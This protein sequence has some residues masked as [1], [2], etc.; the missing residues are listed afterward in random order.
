MYCSS[1]DPSAGQTQIAGRTGLP[2][3]RGLGTWLYEPPYCTDSEIL[4]LFLLTNVLI[5]KSLRIKAS[6]KPMQ[7]IVCSKWIVFLCWDLWHVSC[8]VSCNLS[9]CLTISTI[10]DTVHNDC[11]IYATF[12]LVCFTEI[13]EVRGVMIPWTICTYALL[14]WINVVPQSD[15]AL[16]HIDSRA[17]CFA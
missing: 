2:S 13:T 16:R 7:S 3:L 4:F 9:M 8:N 10:S 14:S 12:V 5:F 17:R 6:A 1:P 15:T 11:V